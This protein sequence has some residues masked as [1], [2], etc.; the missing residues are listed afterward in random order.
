MK[1]KPNII[2][3]LGNPGK[4]YQK[5]YHNVGQLFIQYFADKKDDSKKAKFNAPKG[6][7]FEY[8][9]INGTIFVK[10]LTFMNSSGEAVGATLDYFKIKPGKMLVIHDDS[11]ILLGNY[12]FSLGRNSAGHRGVQSIINALKTKNFWRLRIGVRKPSKVRI[13]AGNLVLGPIQAR[14]ITVL[15]KVFERTTKELLWLG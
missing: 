13:Q 10:P 3:G 6:K 9:K 14:D 11:D 15:K 4:E 5:T 12:K 7:P 2:I 8:A 1:V